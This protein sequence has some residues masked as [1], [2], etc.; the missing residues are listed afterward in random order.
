M[1]CDEDH[2]VGDWSSSAVRGTVCEWKTRRTTAID[3]QFVLCSYSPSFPTRRA[4]VPDSVMGTGDLDLYEHPYTLLGTRY[5]EL[6]SYT[7]LGNFYEGLVDAQYS[8]SELAMCT[9][10]LETLS[11]RYVELCAMPSTR[12]LALCTRS[13]ARRNSTRAHPRPDRPGPHP[14]PALPSLPW[15]SSVLACRQTR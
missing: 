1:L 11:T 3:A 6:N 8:H 13:S 5:V 2:D 7:T 15:P 12:Y 10:T 4:R 9:C 14:G